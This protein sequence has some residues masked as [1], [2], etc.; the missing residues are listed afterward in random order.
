MKLYNSKTTKNEEFVPRKAGE[1]SMYVCGPTVYNEAHIG[2]ARPIIVFDTLRRLFEAQGWNVV[3]ASNFT[4]VDDKIIQKAINEGVDEKTITQRYIDAYELVRGSLHTRPL[5]YA[6]K[7]TETMDAIIAFIER[8]VDI[9]V[10]YNI[11][12]NVYFRVASVENYGEIS[13][14]NVED[15]L[16]GARVEEETEKE[17][18]LDFALWKK[19]NQGIQWDSPWGRGRPGWHTECV[20]MIDERF[21]DMIDIHGG[22]MDLKFPHHENEAAQSKALFGH[23]IATTWMHNGMLNIDGEKMSKSLGN[24]MLAKDVIAKIGANATRWMMLQAHYRAPLNISEEGVL[25]A[26]TELAK[27]EAVLKQAEIKTQLNGMTMDEKADPERMEVF[28]AAMDDDLNTPNG[29]MEI[30]ETV[31]LLNQ[32]L[33]SNTPD[34]KRV[35]SLYQA[36]REMLDVMGIVIPVVQLTQ[37]DKEDYAV[38]NRAKADKD[39]ATADRIRTKLAA[40]GKL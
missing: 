8:L 10:A 2:N 39:F 20:V 13:K 40:Q 6:P 3:Y 32:S 19:T 27:L 23:S 17:S 28:L 21:H 12:G 36:V 15:L 5:T 29:F 9:G 34:V 4:D 33:R 7:V 14:Q 25:Q 31:K 16:V 37:E 30:F 18:P 38:W 22:G 11:D 1:V 26:Q 35:A 24:V